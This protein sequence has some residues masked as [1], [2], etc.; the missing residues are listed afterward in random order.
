MKKV[1]WGHFK[2]LLYVSLGTAAYV[3]LLR[4]LNQ[5]DMRRLPRTVWDAVDHL[6]SVLPL[7]IKV[8]IAKMGPHELGSLNF[9]LG[10]YIQT[11]FG[12]C[13]G[14]KALMDSC[15]TVTGEAIVRPE[16]AADIIIGA[17]WERLRSTHRLRMVKYA[18][19]STNRK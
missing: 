6:V 14:N 5:S 13:S 7:N 12:L 17:L 4:H 11:E 2:A 1:F 3:F 15:R 9:S 10:N 19:S 16:G 8:R 18:E